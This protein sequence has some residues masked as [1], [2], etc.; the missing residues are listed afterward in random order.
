MHQAYGTA[1]ELPELLLALRSA[2][3]DTRRKALDRYY[4]AVH[5]QGDVYTC[6][7]VSLPF[8]YELVADPWTPDRAA[9]VDLLISIGTEAVE[10]GDITYA[11]QADFAGARAVMRA[12]AHVFVDLASDDDPH[13]RRAAVPGLA[14]FVD[15][16]EPLRDR[17]AAATGIAEQLV[18][19]EAVGTL[20]L[21]VPMLAEQAAAWS[22]TVAANTRVAAEVG[23]G[24]LV[25]RVRCSP[26]RIDTDLVPSAVHLLEQ[27]TPM[28][29]S[30]EPESLVVPEAGVP[31]FVT[32]AFADMQRHGRV[33]AWSTGSLQ[34]LHEALADRVL[35]RTALL[36]TQ[37]RSLDLGT[38]LDGISMCATLICGWRGDHTSLI[39]LLGEQLGV[40][41]PELAA[42]AAKA[43]QQCHP[44]AEPARQVLADYVAQHGP[45][46]WASPQP[47]TRRACQEVVRTLARLGDPWAL[48][49]LLLALDDGV[50][51]W[52]AVQV[53]GGLAAAADQLVPRLRR[54]LAAV[55]LT[56]PQ[57]DSS[58]T[59]LVNALAKLGDPAAVP[60]L[61]D[62]LHTAIRQ[63]NVSIQRS[64]LAA[65]GTL[66]AAASGALELIRALLAADKVRG[67]A[68][69]ALWAVSRDSTEVLPLL[70]VL[71]EGRNSFEINAAADVLV[72]IGPAAA[73]AAPRLRELL[74]HNYDWVRVHAATALWAVAGDEVVL[75]VLLQAWAQNSATGNAVVACLNRMGPAAAP[76]LPELRR[77]LALPRRGGR[78]GGIDTDEELQ[79]QGRAIVARFA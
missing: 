1:E 5:H 33:R 49:S 6:T 8:L 29:V 35:D 41:E 75:E 34:A 17:F 51:D 23:L 25:Q 27:V 30:S 55:D 70:H 53:A 78:Y 15:D 20:A 37:L 69:A 66:G 79:R 54:H 48:P 10:R 24:A 31:P 9:I 56:T 22:A 64:V 46:G 28:W 58:A 36:A 40:G 19:V 68:V 61:V 59:A 13:V 67:G 2:D 14:L 16:M 77:Q 76:A 72:E 21:R 26:D 65:L 39:V 63:E 57:W 74:D 73:A 11:G 38:R 45:H 44:I 4:G 42:E 60:V 43:L 62:T 71:L 18:V 47:A 3:A 12:R 52:R 50:D 32:A 7:T